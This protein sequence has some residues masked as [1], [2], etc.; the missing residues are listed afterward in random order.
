MQGFAY[1][2]ALAGR[3]GQTW[4]YQELDAFLAN[5]KAHLPGTKMTFAGLSDPKDR[6]A[7]IRY[8]AANTRESA[9]APGAGAEDGGGPGVRARRGRDRSIADGGGYG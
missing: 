2:D 1:S 5:P 8:L 3:H 9:A 4:T 6:A 7:V